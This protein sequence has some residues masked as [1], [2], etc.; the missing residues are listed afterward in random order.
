MELV[1]VTTAVI[2]GQCQQDY[3][4]GETEKGENAKGP[5]AAVTDK[6]VG[7]D[8]QGEGKADG[9][10]TVGEQEGRQDEGD[11]EHRARTV[12]AAPLD[13][14]QEGER[15]GSE[16]QVGSVGDDG[17]LDAQDYAAEGEAGARGGRWQGTAAS[18][19]R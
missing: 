12:P 17:V 5:K 7:E 15:E 19:S 10:A 9:S 2:E 4:G 1:A 6:L 14:D 16:E 13:E 18:Q 11:G 3:A 8:G